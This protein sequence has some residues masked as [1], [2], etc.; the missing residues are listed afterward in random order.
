MALNIN[1]LVKKMLGRYALVAES[2]NERYFEYFKVEHAGFGDSWFKSMNIHFTSFGEAK[3]AAKEYR[4]KSG[5]KVRVV[6]VELA[7]T[8]LKVR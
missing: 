6:K 7:E 3:K 5:L 1:Q 8:Y 2:K 4:K